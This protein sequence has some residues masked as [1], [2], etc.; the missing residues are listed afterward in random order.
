MYP[1]EKKSISVPKL[2]ESLI[3]SPISFS[4]ENRLFNTVSVVTIIALVIAF[5]SNVVLEISGLFV[6]ATFVLQCVLYY[7]S[8]VKKQYVIP[9]IIYC[10]ASYAYFIANYFMNAGIDG[11]TVFG[12][13][14]TFILIIALGPTSWHRL[15]VVMHTVVAIGMLILEYFNVG[16]YE[17]YSTRKEHFIDIGVSYI[18]SLTIMYFVILY[19]RNNYLKEKRLAQQYAESIVK[20]NEELEELN[21]LKNRLFSIIS[22]DLRAPLNSVQGYLELLTGHPLPENQ[23]S[24]I[25]EQLLHLTKHTQEMLFNL[26]SWSKSQIS[27]NAVELGPV[28]LSGIL[29]G[30]IGVLEDAAMKKGLVLKSFIEPDLQLIAEADMLQ[31]VIRNLINNAI[32]F[33]NLGGEISI[34][35][36][37]KELEG[38]ISVTDNGIG[39]ALQKQKDVFSSRLKSEYGTNKEK[40][41]GLGLYL[42]KELIELQ[43]GKIWFTSQPGV[44]S[45]FFISL[46]AC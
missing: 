15:W 18:I 11:P 14:S 9:A 4:M 37:R 34:R 24:K 13:I 7:F 42:C 8:R 23:R 41:T 35:A 40:G 39:I 16:H 10:F 19:I 43:N 30:T 32:K 6:I 22:H 25:K 33:S 21:Q 2:W 5:V 20:K 44:G 29:D 26:L 46:P 27:G 28:M 17:K 31:L 45:E 12:F 1:S 36:Y 38:V 3:G